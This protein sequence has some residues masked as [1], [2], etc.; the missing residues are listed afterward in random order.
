MAMERFVNFS[1]EVTDGGRGSVRTK[2]ERVE[3]RA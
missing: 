3:R 2:E 1:N